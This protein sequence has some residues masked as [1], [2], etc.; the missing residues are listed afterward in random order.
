[1]NV[2]RNFDIS[3]YSKTIILDFF[4]F[5]GFLLIAVFV[6]SAVL[7]FIQLLSID[8]SISVKS[9]FILLIVL[10]VWYVYFGILFKKTGQTLGMKMFRLKIVPN[11]NKNLSYRQIIWWGI[12]IPLPITIFLEV[13]NMRV[14]PYS[15]LLE[16]KTDTRIMEI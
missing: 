15:T 2:Y 7:F 16:S 11:S 10:F 12:F 4:L 9:N 8:F 3:K 14:P 6:G 5:Y 1:M 13:L